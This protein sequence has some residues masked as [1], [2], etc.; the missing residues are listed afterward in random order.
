MRYIP[1]T[2]HP[3]PDFQREQWLNLNG[4]W[5]F[6][7]DPNDIGLTEGWQSGNRHFSREI[8]VPF[9]WE[10]SYSG[11][12]Q[13]DYQGIAWYK[14]TFTVPDEWRTHRVH[15]KFGAVDW[16]ARVWVNGKFAGVHRG[17]YSPFQL[18]ITDFLQPGSNTVVAR[19]VDDTN[20]EYPSG[21]QIGWYTR[22]S[23]IWQ[24]VYLESTGDAWIRYVH[25]TPDVKGEQAHVDITVAGKP[26]EF[27]VELS[28]LNPGMP[29]IR[30]MV[31]HNGYRTVVRITVQIPDAELWSPDNPHLYEMNV[32]L[33]KAESQ[34]DSV[35][36]YFGMRE[37]T[38]G[39]WGD[40][41]YEYILLNGE[42]V[43]LMGALHQSFHPT[44]IHTYP[45]DNIIRDDI[46]RA[47]KEFGFNCLR[48][49]IK[50]DEPRLYYWADRLGMLILYDLPN[51]RRDNE[52]SRAYWEQMLRDAIARDY[53]HPSVIAWI[54]FNETWGLDDEGYDEQ[55]QDWV[56]QMFHLTRS[57]D[58]TRLIEDNSPCRYDHVLTD[59]NSW[60]FY[61]DNYDKT[62]EHIQHVVDQTAPGSEF[63]YIGGNKQNVE[64]LINSEYGAV[65]AG[66]GDR[67]ISWG[68]K[69]QT[70]ELRKHDKVCGYIYTELCDIEWEHN[71]VMN[72][73]RSRK[74]FGYNAHVPG[75][76]IRNLNA[77]DFLVIDAPP[78]SAH[79]VNDTLLAPVAISHWSSV[80]ASDLKLH[81]QLTGID[82][83]GRNKVYKQGD[84]A[85][86]WERF[87]VHPLGELELTLP[88][89]PALCTLAVWIQDGKGKRLAINYV[90]V[91]VQGDVPVSEKIHEG[92]ILSRFRP[93][94]FADAQWSGKAFLEIDGKVAGC[95]SGY[96]EYRLN[97]PE[98]L[99]PDQIETME[100]VFEGASK[101][102]AEKLDWPSRRK[103]QD[104]PQT[105]AT[106][107]PS[108]VR[109]SLNDV[110]HTE[111][112]FADDP[113]DIRGVLSHMAGVHHGSYGDVTKI[114]FTMTDS[115]Q[116]ALKDDGFLRVR[117]EVPDSATNVGGFSLY[118]DGMGR[119]PFNPH[120]IYRFKNDNLPEDWKSNQDLSH[121]GGNRA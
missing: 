50:V 13:P 66:G 34:I 100:I 77:L 37:I 51:Y 82:K 98:G 104:Y 92:T 113:A 84:R 25:I 114:M 53:N 52:R 38:R 54:L 75:F 9:P 8:A 87:S 118:G 43:Y 60:H 86:S 22:T 35:R 1:R 78:C 76:S 57:L 68:F 12:E 26:D 110:A 67:D 88:Q 59:I 44:S 91:L 89:E 48:I 55:T 119:Y 42:P 58:A 29:E 116:T 30:R 27:A 17:G 28:F 4:I 109:L 47:K 39:K 99:A 115:L 15:L 69:Y 14:R 73:D 107:H 85:A 46:D 64:P 23:G 93:M 7:F 40:K 80:E 19:V 105:D 5:E 96:F 103:E 61:I 95:G 56:K 63:N 65:S 101:A 120:I 70:N 90:N 83:R 117:F 6:E 11:I 94:D 36:T 24:T 108:D 21:K 16:G 3:R 2:E 45:S 18:E 49:H 72:Y 111:L 33:L 74:E 102:D 10:S 79:G 121:N 62:R 31:L 81:W 20:P 106:K 71:G 112:H 32:T 41:P 97:L